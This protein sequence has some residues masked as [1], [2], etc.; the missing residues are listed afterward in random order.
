MGMRTG[1][2]GRK[3]SSGGQERWEDR[4]EMGKMTENWGR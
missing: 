2:R 4:E 1:S 3:T